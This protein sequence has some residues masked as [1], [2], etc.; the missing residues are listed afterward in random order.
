[1]HTADAIGGVRADLA[2]VRPDLDTSALAVTGRILRLAGLVAARRDAVLAA[3]GLRQSDYDVLATL[4]RRGGDAGLRAGTIGAATMVT[5]GGLT[6]QLDRLEAAELI[7]RLPDP[8][9]GRVVR[10]ALTT[11]GRTLVD[12]ALDAVN[13]DE[14]ELL[15]NAG[16][17]D[18]ASRALQQALGS[19]LH[20][21]EGA[22]S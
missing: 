15:S 8:G 4:R 7:Q 2:R 14:V 1:M 12:R 6:K 18:D 3:L 13:D 9:D 20:A 17:D 19:M 5:S 10:V 11:E 16:V 22:A 21:L